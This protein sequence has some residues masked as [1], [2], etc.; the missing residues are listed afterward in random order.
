MIPIAQSPQNQTP[1]ASQLIDVLRQG[2]L[3]MYQSKELRDAAAKTIVVESSR[4]YRLGKAKG[5]DRVDPIIALAMGV[6]LAGREESSG[7]RYEV[8]NFYTGERQRPNAN[9]IDDMTGLPIVRQ[10]PPDFK[11]MARPE[12]EA[13]P[14]APVHPGVTLWDYIDA[15]G[16]D[17]DD[18]T[19]DQAYQWALSAYRKALAEY[20]QRKKGAAAVDRVDVTRG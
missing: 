2:R 13:D 12:T 20:R 9:Q 18:P 3:R 14:D 11:P 7:S 4:G 6:L 17:K 19:L 8:Y 15:H 5:S 1:M 10:R 16:L